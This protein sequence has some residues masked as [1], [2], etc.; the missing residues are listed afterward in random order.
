[1][2]A[3]DTRTEGTRTFSIVSAVYNVSRYLDDFLDSLARQTH[4][5]E[6]LDIVLVDDGSTDDSLEKC[7][8]FAAQWPSSVQVITK[9]N[10]GQ[11]SARNAGLD[12]VRGEW[13]TF[14][15]P[16]DFLAD[17]YFAE[18]DAFLRQSAEATP[19]LL[20]T[21]LHILFEATGQLKDA[22]PLRTKFRHGNRVY[23]L[24]IEADYLQMHCNSA[25]FQADRIRRAHLRFD[26][27]IRPT[28]EDCHFVASYLLQGDRATV[29]A[30]ATARYT[31]RKR[32]DESSS[33]ARS[34]ADPDKYS[35]VPRYGHLALLE[36]AERVHGFVPEWL[37]NMVL[38]D[39][40]WYMKDDSSLTA[41][42]GSIAPEILDE[43]HGLVGQILAHISPSTIDIFSVTPIGDDIRFVLLHAYAATGHVPAA[44]RVSDTDL[45]QGLVQLKYRYTGDAPVEWVYVDGEP[46]TP[47]HAKTRSIEYFGRSLAKERIMWVPLGNRTRITLNGE[48]VPIGGE[49]VRKNGYIEGTVTKGRSLR[50]INQ[51]PESIRHPSESLISR[52][53]K[54][55]RIVRRATSRSSLLALARRTV[56]SIT[57]H[58]GITRRLFGHAW[59]FMDKD[60]LAGDNGEHLYRYVQKNHPEIN[61]WFV[62]NRTS[63]DWDRLKRDGVRVI[64]YGTRRWR[65]L[66]LNAD[67]LAS[68]H[69][70]NYVV[71]PLNPR[72]YG[73]PRWRF[74][75]LQHG[76]IKDDLSRWLNSKKLD[77]FVTASP[78]EYESIVADDTPYRFTSREVQLT[79][80]PRHD[81]L[82]AKREAVPTD[83]RDLILVMPTWR[84]S[85][86]GKALTTENDRG[87]KDGFEASEYAEQY[88]RLLNSEKL[89]DLATAHGLT[90][91]FMPHPNMAPYLADFDVPSYV[92]VHSYEETDVQ[93][94]LARGRVHV[95]DYS[96]MAFNA[97]MIDLPTLYFQFDQAAFYAGNHP[98]RT[99]YFDY[100]RDGFGP[101]CT[102]LASL[103]DAMERTLD[104]TLEVDY[105]ARMRDVFEYRD[106]NNCSRTFEA[107]LS[108][109]EPAAVKRSRPAPVIPV[110]LDL[111]ADLPSYDT[112]GG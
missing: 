3:S 78:A 2:A 53:T 88:T 19:L 54:K 67:H 110:D 30:V 28:F 52:L 44:V 68:S 86:M 93:L 83:K 95:T 100:E 27:R 61:A 81:A 85:L 73:E 51:R 20:S 96:S 65:L 77:L 80:L 58:S 75:F 7:R 41:L 76:V 82:I 103:E 34:G 109:N 32:A 29:G 105:F 40:A 46:V 107:M 112:I 71:N 106:T 12:H 50:I 104:G 36:T 21:A 111:G 47:M 37:Q 22:H 55:A 42:S 64:P 62:I 69:V 70:D 33:L 56:L 4:G 99:G 74:T 14:T 43:F 39:L 48:F 108:L 89:R 84:K 49:V 94:L 102:T 13:V 66:M 11:G 90:I 15:D 45:L 35:K 17:D 92:E 79:G 10:G 26:E 97:A 101:L 5:I 16:D 8:A 87:R 91:A 1:M 57:L 63:A 59:V 60:T 18:V 72:V 6:N 23:D 24:G 9:V 98:G 38:Y 31:Y 25:L